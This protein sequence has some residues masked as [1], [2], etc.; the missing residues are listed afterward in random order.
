MELIAI[1]TGVISSKQIVA[2]IKGEINKD[3]TS[4]KAGGI[5]PCLGIVKI[6]NDPAS[7]QYFNAK[8][9]RAS[10]FGVE[11]RILTLE[12]DVSQ[13][14]VNSEVRKISDDP[15]V[16]GVIVESPV[17]GY[18]NSH[19]F[20]NLIPPEK[21]VDGATFV[22]LGKLMSGEPC[23]SPATP[24]SVMEFMSEIGVPAGVSVAIINRTITVGKPLSMMLLSRNYTPIIC[25]SKTNDLKNV[26]RNSD[27][28]VSAA[29]KPS[30]IG[31]EFVHDTSV[32][33]DVG[34]N[35]VDGK[36]VGD[37]DFENIKDK[38]SAIT[39]VPG[40]VGAVTSLMIFKNLLD[41]IKMQGL[42]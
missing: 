8:I 12:A 3:I 10:E 14:R 29:G 16:H 38:V 24:M 20:I 2:R 21:D 30:L 28:I 32:V 34:I 13:E 23:L 19:E 5:L 31:P 1:L 4:I 6:G 41:A 15:D 9:K 40:G 27:V 17:P 36:L 25:H 35:I 37:A 33:I 22:N 39:P 11:T 7:E 26:C 42:V 18:L